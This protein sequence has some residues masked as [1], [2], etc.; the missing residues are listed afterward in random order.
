MGEDTAKSLSSQQ[1]ALV[2]EGLGK[3]RAN[4]FRIHAN[5]K[6]R[7]RYVIE[8]LKKKVSYISRRNIAVC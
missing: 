8:S 6:N 1:E 2:G 4:V 5:L 3:F 7:L